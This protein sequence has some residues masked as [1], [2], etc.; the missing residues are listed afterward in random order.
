MNYNARAGIFG[1]KTQWVGG[2]EGMALFIENYR[3]SVH[4][5]MNS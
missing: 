3:N 2:G 4:E 5:D 1:A